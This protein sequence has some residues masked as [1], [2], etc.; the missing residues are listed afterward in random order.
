MT[1]EFG[2]DTVAGRADDAALMGDDNAIDDGVTSKVPA[3]TAFNLYCN[4]AAVEG[5]IYSGVSVAII[6]RSNFW[7]SRS[8]ASKARLAA[9]KH[10][11]IV[12]SF[13]LH[14]WRS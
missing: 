14:Q 2:E 5:E 6:I 3:F 8:A 4:T 11:S 1:S 13:S 10:K 9:L 7:G 12:D